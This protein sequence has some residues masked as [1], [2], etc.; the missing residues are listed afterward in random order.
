[1]KSGLGGIG[2][3]DPERCAVCKKEVPTPFWCRKHGPVCVDCY[4]WDYEKC[5]VC[6]QRQYELEE[7]GGA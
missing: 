7:R 1:M 6:A 2:I 3:L 5:S 4:D